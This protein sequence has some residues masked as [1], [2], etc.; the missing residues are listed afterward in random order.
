MI[1]EPLWSGLGLIGALNARVSGALPREASGVSIDTRT[2]CPGDLFLAIRGEA[3]DGHD[4]V[5]A[6]FEKGAAAAVVD[7]EHA[8]SYAGINPL[9]IVKDVQAALERL[10]AFARARSNAY[11]AAITGSVGKTTTKDMAGLVFSRFGATH[12]SAASYNNHWGVPLSLARMHPSTRYGIFELGMNHAGEIAAL[13]DMVKPHVAI[14]TRVAP[15]HLAHFDSLEAIANAKAEIFQGVSEGGVAIINR[16]D[17]S[18]PRLAEAASASKAGHLLS[19]GASEGADA[20]LVSYETQDGIGTA[21]VE[22]FGRLIQYRIGAPG[23]HIAL[24]ALA[25]LLTAY[26][27]DLDLEQAAAAFADYA[28]SAGRGRRETLDLGGKSL[29][30]IDESYNANP[31]SMRAAFETLAAAQPGPDGRRIAVLGDMLELGPRAGELHAELGEDLSQ[32]GVDLLFTAGPLMAR[33]YYAAPDAMRGAHRSSAAE[34]EEPLLAALR[35][36]DVVMVKGS[37]SSRMGAIVA[38]L[39][40]AANPAAQAGEGKTEC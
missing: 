27:F 20:R 18:F 1:Q 10:G 4:F 40:K 16:D 38:A 21:Q 33:A 3:R 36:G 15:A 14:V 17:P 22:I 5:P 39:H 26:V 29:T 34:L 30:L 28:V 23:R 37:N 32:L 8:R 35:S 13:V 12:V 24:N 2:L 9:Y 31:A 11:L 25:V 6:A 7:E 19:F